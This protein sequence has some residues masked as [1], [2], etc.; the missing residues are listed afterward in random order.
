MK[1]FPIDYL[2]PFDRASKCFNVIVETPKGSQVKYS[3]AAEKGLFFITKVLP[4]GMVYPF[5]FG[6][7]PGTLAADGDPLDMLILNEEPVIAGCLLTVRLIAV[8]KAV[9]T[10]TENGSPLRNDRLVGQAIGKEAPQ[11][12]R[13]L[14]LEKGMVNQI[15][16]FFTNYNRVFG[17]KF[18]VLGVGGP[19]QARKLVR[20][21]VELYRKNGGS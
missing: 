8:I 5:N 1:K 10:E 19:G 11:E 2:E 13:M 17:K 12:L 20:Q 9:Q 3:Y 15:G 14:R 7:I 21:A 6:F 16:T 4:P 18:K